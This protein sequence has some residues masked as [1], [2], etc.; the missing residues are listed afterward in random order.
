MITC[1]ECKDIC[2]GF[3]YVC[4]QC[5]FKLDV[6]CAALT[7]HKTGVSL[8]KERVTELHHF[9]HQHMLFFCYYNDPIKETRCRICE[10][11]IF[12]PAYFCH[13]SCYFIVHES[14]FR[15]P[16]KIQVPFHLN[17]MLV[18]Q[19]PW[20]HSNPQCY[21]CPLNIS[22][23]DFAYSCEDCQ[24]NLH[25]ICANYLK[26][27]LKC[28]SHLDDLYYF[29]TDYQLLCAKSS[30]SWETHF[31]CHKCG[32]ICKGEPF[33]RCLECSINFHLK[34]VPAPNT[35]KSKYHLHP[36]T[37]TDSLV[38]D[39]SGKYYC[40]FCEEERNPKDH[41]Y[42]CKECDGQTIA[43]IECVL[44]RKISQKKRREEL[45]PQSIFPAV[46]EKL[47]TI[48]AMVSG[49]WSDDRYLQLKA[50]TQFRKLL[51]IEPS[52]PIDQ[53]IQAGVV[54]RFV[55]FLEREDFPQ[56]QFE[57][58]WALTIIASTTSETS[59]VVI[60]NGAV[61]IFVKLL[62]SPRAD[63]SE[64]SMRALG[65]IAGDSPATRDVVLG[66]GALLP[67]LAHLNENAKLSVLRIA[68]WTLSMFLRGKPRPCFHQVKPALPTLARLIHSNDEQ[69]LCDACWAFSYL[70]DG[71]NDEIQGVVEADVCGRL[72]ELLLHPCLLV[73]E[74]A[75]RTVGNITS[76]D[77]AQ[78][79]VLKSLFYFD[80]SLHIYNM[81]HSVFSHIWVNLDATQC[82]AF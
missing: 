73:L 10:L 31:A 71:T 61:P 32:N 28:E 19:Q 5:N 68:T 48:P 22:S 37:L 36:L 81:N 55:E 47:G 3:I 72:V 40:D 21:A 56:L 77:D 18:I 58:A 78:T 35:V 74:P 43:H 26:R 24:L 45:Q 57:A 49:V 8:E 50:T 39:D 23:D 41:V 63:V 30:P 65:N 34:C 12:G 11:P 14:C 59:K 64:Q 6:K 25:P 51:S 60:D 44:T 13:L 38:E 80:Y 33:Y 82:H 66:H 42:Y 76:R 27:P 1:D 54:P 17:H 9:S 2:G 70:S 20:E 79:Q 4:E 67:L 69:V 75:L 16:Q 52:Q 62:G 46:E 7:S 53:V 29:G 15:L